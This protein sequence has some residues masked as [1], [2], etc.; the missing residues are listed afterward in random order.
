M[1]SSVFRGNAKAD[2]YVPIGPVQFD[3]V[4]IDVN[5]TVIKLGDDDLNAS[6]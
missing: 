1:R 5:S 2:E 6:R 4:H 3:A